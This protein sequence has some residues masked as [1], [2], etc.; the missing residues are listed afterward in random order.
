MEVIQ[1][2]SFFVPALR[3]L[4]ISI[5]ISKLSIALFLLSSA[6]IFLFLYRFRLLFCVPSLLLLL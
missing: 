4:L 6:L 2:V 5:F 3:F 1:F